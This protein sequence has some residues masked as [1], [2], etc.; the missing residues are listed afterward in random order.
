M[1]KKGGGMNSG[2]TKKKLNARSSTTSE[3][4]TADDFLPKIVWVKN[5]LGDQ[6]IKL[7]Q[8]VLFQDNQSAMLLEKKGRLYCGKCTRI[9][10]IWYFTINDCFDRGGPQN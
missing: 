2:S 10:K 4:V 7:D 8:N 1:R 5:F 9:I 3:L 6:N